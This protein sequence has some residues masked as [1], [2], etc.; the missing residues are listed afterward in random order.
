LAKVSFNPIFFVQIGTDEWL[1]ADDLP[2]L[3]SDFSIL[4]RLK[5]RIE[6]AKK[7]ESGAHKATKEAHE[8][9]WLKQ[10]AEALDIEID[11]DMECVLFLLSPCALNWCDGDFRFSD[12]G[13]ENGS[14]GRKTRK[15]L[16]NKAA[17]VKALKAELAALLAK[18]LMMR[19]V[20]AKY[21]TT[22]NTVDFVDQLVGGTSASLSFSS[23]GDGTD[24]IRF[25]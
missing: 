2:E 22:R 23:F 19:G 9:N 24:V 16:K 12:E 5:E 11:S 7:V 10:A 25:R 14:S 20:S 18:P 13:G 6:L 21:L 4:D 15:A 1:A 8:D 17:K 3:P